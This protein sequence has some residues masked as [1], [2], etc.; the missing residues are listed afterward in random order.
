MPPRAPAALSVT[1]IRIEKSASAAR[2]TQIL[3]PLITHSSPSR[4]ARVV[5][6]AG[7]VPA[8][9]SEIA[10]AEVVSPATYGAR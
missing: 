8:P 1:A 3:R 4:T 10:I 6:A 2:L 5:M 9:G 7:S